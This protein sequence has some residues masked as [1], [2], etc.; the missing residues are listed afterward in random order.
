[1]A[2]LPSRQIGP[3]FSTAFA[4]P[5]LRYPG[6]VTQPPFEKWMLF[7]VKNGR[8]VLRNQVL[9][10]KGTNVDRTLS[11]ISLY[12][13]QNALQSTLTV[14]YDKN[15]LGPFVGAAVEL[16]A[17]SGKNLM[18]GGLKN[19]IEG[20]DGG[21]SAPLQ[22][23]TKSFK[24]GNI[25]SIIDAVKSSYKDAIKADVQMEVD[26]L[27]NGGAARV[28]GQRP[29]PRTDILFNTQEYRTH[30]FDFLLVPRNLQEAKAIDGIIHAFQ[31]YMLPAYLNQQAT[32]N[33][34]GSFLIGFPY[35]FEITIKQGSTTLEHVNKI[36]RSVLTNIEI[37]HAAGEKV[38]FVEDGDGDLYP[39]MTRMSLRFQE[40]R[41]LGRDSN[42][43]S[44]G[45]LTSTT[46]EDPRLRPQQ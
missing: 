46:L 2:D 37:D 41:L 30:E 7:E 20:N 5:A 21:L 32:Q 24:S 17:Q 14:A 15:D 4:S 35:E 6:N 16:L 28:F 9:D 38:A 44:R 10:E 19:W 1:M 3:G 13:P 42:E 18:N 27:S 23:I 34:L 31:Y 33:Q 39:V 22:S 43:I 45:D 25:G 29:N 12:L 11:S 8:H 40:V 36:A 26:S